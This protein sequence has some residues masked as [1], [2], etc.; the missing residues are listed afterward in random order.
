MPFL[1]ATL[2]SHR[3][4]DF[5]RKISA[6]LA[7]GTAVANPH[8]LLWFAAVMKICTPSA[9]A[10]TDGNSVTSTWPRCEMRTAYVAGLGLTGWNPV[11]ASVAIPVAAGGWTT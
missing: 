8:P 2:Y 7:S 9:R 11:E 3:A 5:P 1:G 6:H 4:A 10:M